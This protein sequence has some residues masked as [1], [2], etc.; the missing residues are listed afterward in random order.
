LHSPTIP[1]AA[2]SVSIARISHRSRVC[3]Q[4]RWTGGVSVGVRRW[5][6]MARLLVALVVLGACTRA[7]AQDAVV[8]GDTTVVAPELDASSSVLA[9]PVEPTVSSSAAPEDAATVASEAG[10]QGAFALGLQLAAD[11]TFTEPALTPQV[12]FA[13]QVRLPD[14]FNL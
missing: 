7:A 13:F 1:A 11:G 3:T 4:H 12:G 9:S 10:A 2:S 6:N 5:R 14:A 8:E